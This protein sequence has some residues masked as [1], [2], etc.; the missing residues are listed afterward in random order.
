VAYIA[1]MWLEG[2]WNVC[3]TRDFEH[4]VSDF[5]CPYSII[6]YHPSHLEL[7]TSYFP[8]DDKALLSRFLLTSLRSHI[9]LA[10][11][12]LLG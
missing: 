3:D 10:R 12:A 8:A 2:D 5:E 7:Y 6:L 11:V 9:S 4:Q 1:F